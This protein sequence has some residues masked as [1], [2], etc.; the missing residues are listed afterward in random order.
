MTSSG[1]TDSLETYDVDF[2]T[3]T[4]KISPVFSTPE[5]S[6]SISEVSAPTWRRCY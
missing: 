1:T 2:K 5:Q 4:V 6:F 3:S